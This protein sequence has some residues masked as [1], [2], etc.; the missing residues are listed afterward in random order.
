MNET[1]LE[2]FILKIPDDE[3]LNKISALFN[4]NWVYT[5]FVGAGISMDPPSCVP[6]ARMFVSELFKYYAPKYEANSLLGLDSLRYELVVEKIENL[7]DK[8]LKFLD[9]LDEVKEPNVN[10]VFLANMTM[11]YCNVITTNFDFLLEMALK[12]KLAPY[13]LTHPYHK[14]VMIIITKEDY[15]KNVKGQ[16][17][18][19]KI[20]GSKWDCIKG[21]NTKN[22][23]ITTISAL[24][25]EREKGK[26]FAIEPYKKRLIDSMMQY[27][28]LVIMGYSGSDDFDIGP[29]LRELTSIKRLI[30]IEHDQNLETEEIFIYNPLKSLKFAPSSDLSKQDNMLLEIAITRN[31]EVY[32]IKTNTINF[33]KNRLAP[34]FKE[35]F[36]TLNEAPAKQIPSFSEYMEK[37]HINAAASSKYRLAHEIYSELGEIQYAE[38]TALTGLTLAKE[39]RKDINEMYFTNALG[40]LYSTK[41]EIDKAFEK[42]HQALQLIE[43]LNQENEKIGVLI[44]IGELYRKKADFKNALK[45]TIEASNIIN[46]NTPNLLK[47]SLLNSL[48][49]IYNTN[50]DLQNAIKEIKKALEIA[51][52]MGDLSRKALCYNNLAGIYSSQGLLELALKNASEALKIDELLGDLDDMASNL[53]TI[54]N[55]YSLAGYNDEALK[56]L[57]RAYQTADK[58]KKIRIK[59]LA[60]NAMGVIYFTLGRNDDAMKIYNETYKIRQDLGDLS[61]QAT[62]LNN[63]G[64]IYRAK[65][66][67]NK[68]YE[69]F[70]KSIGIAEEIGEKTHLAVRYGN[71]ASIHEARRE[72][73]KALEEYKKAFAI[74]KSLQNMHEAAKQLFNI[75][76]IL[77][78]M[79]QHDECIK[80]YTEALNILEELKIKPGIA[81]ALNNLGTVYYKFKRDYKKSIDFLQRSVTIYKEI[82]DPQMLLTSQQNLDFIKKEYEKEK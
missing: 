48:G 4:E 64:L 74:A 53:N 9:Y 6:S 42:L 72:F 41:G 71:R 65:R 55:I 21:R 38:R 75:G 39:E 82:E 56:Y 11:R 5:F 76:G 28:D 18:I 44:N 46:D 68:A 24:G 14:K 62:S 27:R 3:K 2:D 51:E 34:I 57:E 67:Y 25:K 70:N 69:L 43:R 52:I 29:M 45:Y 16:F 66:D 15:E 12:N 60:G 78:D 80:K 36:D 73:E 22:S 1:N 32:K 77:G 30:W 61:G 58:I 63:M 37:N 49:V 54:G 23:L 50:G 8:D 17:P 35:N 7:F 20:H 81:R 79:G 59:S 33:V 40:L 19:V 47:F 31:I 26:T 13:P 10:H